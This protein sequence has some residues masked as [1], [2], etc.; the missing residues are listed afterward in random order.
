MNE[1]EEKFIAHAL[2]STGGR[3]REAAQILG[4]SRKGLFLKRRRRGMV[5]RQTAASVEH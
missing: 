4:L 3:V 5:T 1:L 2:Q